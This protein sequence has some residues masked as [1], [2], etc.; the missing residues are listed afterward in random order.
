MGNP[1]CVPKYC[2]RNYASSSGS[3]NSALCGSMNSAA[4][5]GNVNWQCVIYKNWCCKSQMDTIFS[6]EKKPKPSRK[7]DS[8][9]CNQADFEWTG[10]TGGKVVYTYIHAH[11][12]KARSTDK[13]AFLFEK[14]LQI[15]TGF[16]LVRLLSER[17]TSC[18]LSPISTAG[19]RQKGVLFCF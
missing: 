17:S 18:L 16:L 14:C 1:Q 4:W 8:L 12:L 7:G 3:A 10:L 13:K 9:Q 2:V 6:T 11:N 19:W 15:I 5:Y